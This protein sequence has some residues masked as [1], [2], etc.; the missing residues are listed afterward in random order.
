LLT[1]R[2]GITI[3]QVRFG[4]SRSS[5]G[6][7]LHQAKGM[8]K[9]DH[10]SMH[11]SNSSS[12]VSVL[13]LIIVVA[14]IT[15][16]SAVAVIGIDRSRNSLKL[17]NSARVFAGYLEKARI[18]AIRRHDATSIDIKGPNTYA[19]TMDFGGTGVLT[20]RTFNLEPGIVFTDSS[21]NPY[22][23]DGNGNVTSPNGEAVAWADFNWRGRTAQCSM[24]F[25]LKNSNSNRSTVQVAGS[26]DVTVDSAVSTP[27]N[28]SITNVNSSVD[29]SNSAV[30]LGT[31]AHFELN[32]CSVNGGGGTYIPPPSSTCL[33]G[34]ISSSVGTTSI[35]KNGG[36]TASVTITV[37]GSGTIN[38]VANSNLS[39]TPSSQ[40]V[41]ASTGGTFTF[42][43][44]SVTRARASNPPFTVVFSNPCNSVT[45]YVTVT[46]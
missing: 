14:V 9:M 37:T 43:I 28:V 27:A 34:S 20:T 46:N 12:G 35:R 7:S 39:V 29:V 36:S 16:I 10:T 32:P 13:E 15:I 17:Q 24:L 44:S 8:R 25:R 21:N 2:D 18:D 31:A 26:G 3:A 22:A 38:A 11:R 33:G 41:S 45:V 23:V 5:S 30:V 19:V 4:M 6:G 42:T 1:A 40:S